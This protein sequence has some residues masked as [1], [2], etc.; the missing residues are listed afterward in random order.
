MDRR[1][2]PRAAA[3][4]GD[5]SAVF[6]LNRRNAAYFAFQ[7]RLASLAYEGRGTAALDA[8]REGCGTVY[9]SSTTGRRGSQKTRAAARERYGPHVRRKRD[10]TKDH[11]V[12]KV[13]G[14]PHPPESNRPAVD[15]A[16]DAP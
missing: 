7:G 12:G 8:R 5:A 14:R 1:I 13:N 2:A 9:T 16:F 6:T 3:D 11:P 10:P 4:R 15:I